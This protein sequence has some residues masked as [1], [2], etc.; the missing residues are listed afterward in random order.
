MTDQLK[1]VFSLIDQVSGPAR[2]IQ[3][4]LKS[5]L[6]YIPSLKQIGSGISSV[7]GGVKTGITGLFGVL[8]AVKWV[9]GS[10]IAG[11]SYVAY[12]AISFRDDMLVALK[13]L[14]ETEDSAS[15]IF[16][17]INSIGKL[18]KWSTE[19]VA[20]AMIQLRQSGFKQDTAEKIYLAMSDI[21]STDVNGKLKMEQLSR[22]IKTT[23]ASGKL[24]LDKLNEANETARFLEIY[25]NQHKTTRAQAS[26]LLSKG[27][28]DLQETVNILNEIATAGGTRAVGE[29]SKM[30]G[31]QTMSGQIESLKANF[32]E[33]FLGVDSKEFVDVL[34]KINDMFVEIMPLLKAVGLT[35]QESFTAAAGP[36]LWLVGDMVK[37][38][39]GLPAL[40]KRMGPA[41]RV[42]GVLVGILVGGAALLAYGFVE[43]I[44]FIG[45]AIEFL[46]NIIIR[47]PE[48]F[49]F[50]FG[51]IWDKVLK[52]FFKGIGDIVVW[53][54]DA[55]A[56]IGKVLYEVGKFLIIN[57]WNGI[58]SSATWLVDKV[59]GLGGD[60][61]GALGF[62][63][64]GDYA[65]TAG[66]AI[67]NK[68]SNSNTTNNA[69]T[70]SPNITVNNYGVGSNSSDFGQ[71]SANGTTNGLRRLGWL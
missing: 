65:A 59:T 30:A 5:S 62:G 17:R 13:A 19:D 12:N 32:A 69:Q 20:N 50:S 7:Y 64:G 22:L 26:A 4:S 25:A 23:A 38:F 43:A 29:V 14:G 36:I 37:T 1:F 46:Y 51:M 63:G 66:N 45:A 6:Q 40:I 33:L 58:A 53:I 56:G 9:A 8:S 61:A 34:A 67:A 11:T 48:A 44:N 15:A 60:I 35:L 57:L 42:I 28:I 55:F 49:A 47:I 70:N 31:L 68:V 41:L 18:T 71:A 2:K 3:Q 52:P 27:K 21:A 54:V 39:G 10:L 16:N 24:S